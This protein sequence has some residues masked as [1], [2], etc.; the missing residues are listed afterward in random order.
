MRGIE[1]LDQKIVAGFVQSDPG[2]LFPGRVVEAEFIIL[3]ISEDAA[4]FERRGFLG[5]QRGRAPAIPRAAR[6]SLAS[7]KPGSRPVI[8]GR[9][10]ERPDVW[11]PFLF[12]WY[13]AKLS[14]WQQLG[15]DWENWRNA[16]LAAP[17]FSSLARDAA[18]FIA[19][20]RQGDVESAG[21]AGQAM[22]AGLGEEDYSALAKAVFV[23]LAGLSQTVIVCRL[24]TV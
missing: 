4:Q 6:P 18:D 14:R 13:R 10:R 2:A 21:L 3:A 17:R 15:D 8:S 11:D 5:A 23:T 9:V 16:S 1:G 24:I 12:E 7:E 19:E 20:A 22:A